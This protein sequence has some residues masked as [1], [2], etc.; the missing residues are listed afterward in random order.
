MTLSLTKHDR[1]TLFKEFEEFLKQKYE[2]KFIPAA[3][4][5]KKLSAFE[6]VVK[7][8]VENS[9]LNYSEI[10]RELKK[11]RQVIWTTYKRSQ[12]KHRK[13]FVKI[14]SKIKIPMSELCSEK[15]S[16]SELVVA[17]LKDILKMRNTEIA[18]IIK[19]DPRT[20]WTLYMRYKKKNE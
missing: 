13:R 17:Y 16:I 15:A 7:Y 12:K 4:F 6:T 20:V 2:D 18:E 8:L 5:N 10:G 19:R 1:K 14:F 3:I 11:D 9:E